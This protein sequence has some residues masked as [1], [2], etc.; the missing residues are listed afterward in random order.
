MTMMSHRKSKISTK[1]RKR[2]WDEITVP[3]IRLTGQWLRDAGF[4]EGR[5]INIEVLD[6]KLIIRLAED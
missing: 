5:Q 2:T 1:F 4:T 6:N 3:Q